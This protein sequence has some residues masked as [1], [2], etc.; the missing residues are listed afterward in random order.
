MGLKRTS[1][2]K[3]SALS[4]IN[5]MVIVSDFGLDVQQYQSEFCRLTFSP[6][7]SCPHCAAAK[8]LI[9]HGS[10]RRI[11]CD[12]SR[13]FIIQVK[14][15]LC[16]LCRHTVSLLPSFCLPHRHYLASTIQTVLFLRFQAQSSW[17]VIRQRF[18]PSEVPALSSCREWTTRFAEASGVYLKTLLHQL[19]TWQLAPGKLELAITDISGFSQGPRQLLAA[20]PHLVAW[21]SDNGLRMV[22]GGKRW[23]PTLWQWGH[24]AKLGRLV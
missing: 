2:G 12:E 4:P 3:Q 23:L 9:G 14:R 13:S 24:G 8:D 19:A 15:F 5:R 10:Y 11:A 17:Q 21:L 22:E 18:S 20:V 7:R 1:C 6:P 16:P